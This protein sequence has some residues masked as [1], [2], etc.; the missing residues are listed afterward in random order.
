[1]SQTF[2]VI[3]HGQASGNEPEAPLTLKGIEQVERLV[4]LLIQQGF[5]DF[6]R[7]VTSPYLRAGQTAVLLARRLE[8]EMKADPRLVERNLGSAPEDGSVLLDELRKHDENVD[9]RFPNGESNREVASRVLE[10]THE[11]LNLNEGFLLIT[12]RISMALLIRQYEPAFSFDRMMALANPAAYSITHNND[13]NHFV[14][15]IL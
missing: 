8:K 13:G 9:L 15:R 3:R 4:D 5:T 7:I 2:Y 6:S 10:L 11:L 12:H 14:K 1:M